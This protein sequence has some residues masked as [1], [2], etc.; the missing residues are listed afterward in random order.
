[1]RRWRA[2]CWAGSYV[3]RYLR[4]APGAR[5]GITGAVPARL[6]QYDAIAGA[7]PLITVGSVLLI[8]LI[9]AGGAAALVVGRLDFF[10]AF[11]PGLALTALIALAVCLTFIPACL[12]LLGTRML[13]GAASAGRGLLAP[14]PRDV[15]ARGRFATPRIALR[16][17]N[18]SRSRRGSRG[19]GCSR[20]A[21]SAHV[22]SRSRSCCSASAHWRW[23]RAAC[24]GSTSA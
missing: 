20:H 15:L 16:R 5:A 21:S 23:A 14:A 7:L 8:G 17:R 12:A 3:R 9:V 4:P 22:R 19:G 1:M 24:G 13:G 6:A 18:G 2:R 10:R 11:G